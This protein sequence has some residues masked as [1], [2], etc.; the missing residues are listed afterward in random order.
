[1]ESVMDEDMRA[2]LAWAEYRRKLSKRLFYL[3]NCQGTILSEAGSDDSAVTC[4][5]ALEPITGIR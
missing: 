4:N 5:N 1:L 2:A 3:R